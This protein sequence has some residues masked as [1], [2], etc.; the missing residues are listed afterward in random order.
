[1][2]NSGKESPHSLQQCELKP[3]NE[4]FLAF[5][6]KYVLHLS[7]NGE[8]K[9]SPNMKAIPRIKQAGKADWPRRKSRALKNHTM[10]Q[11]TVSLFTQKIFPAIDDF[12]ILMI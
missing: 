7:S 11:M 2:N 5:L 6:I 10:M 9:S 3:K 1:M 8:I 4:L 12:D